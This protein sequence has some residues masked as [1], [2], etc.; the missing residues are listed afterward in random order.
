LEKL[1]P[2]YKGC[3]V[4]KLE[5]ILSSTKFPTILESVLLTKDEAYGLLGRAVFRRQALQEAHEMIREGMGTYTRV[6]EIQSL[7]E[8][9]NKQIETLSSY[10]KGLI[11][12]GVKGVS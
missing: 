4:K 6:V 10:L 7:L 2:S 9:G 8:L 11:Y 12:Q 5:P 3:L 1:H